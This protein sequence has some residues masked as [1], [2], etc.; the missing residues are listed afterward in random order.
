MSFLSSLITADFCSQVDARP[1]TFSYGL[2][3]GVGVNS[4]NQSLWPSVIFNETRIASNDFCASVTPPAHCGDPR[5]THG[6][7]GADVSSSWQPLPQY[8]ALDTL[9]SDVNYNI[10]YGQDRLNLFTHYF[11]PSPASNHPLPNHPITVLSDA[12]AVDDVFFDSGALGLGSSSTAIKQLIDQGRIN[13]NVVGMYL[14]TAY[15]RAGGTQNGSI[16]IG[17]YDSGRF[18]GEPH[19]YP[20]GQTSSPAVSPLKIH[21]KQLSLVTEDG[22]TIPFVTDDGFDGHIST[23]QYPMELPHDTISAL[24]TAINASPSNNDEGSLKTSQ[25]FK[26]NLTITLDDGYEITFPPEWISNASNLTPF[27]AIT[28]DTDNK[29]IGVSRPLIFGAAFLHHLYMT[30]D[31][32]ESSFYLADAKV[33]DNYV[34]PQS[35]CA[36]Q[37]PVAM[38]QP[39]IAKFV[40]MGLIGAIL[41]GLI[42]GTAII[43]VIYFYFRRRAQ[44]KQS[45]SAIS[46]MEGGGATG[47]RH[48]S[49]MR[50]RSILRLDRKTG[51]KRGSKDVTFGDVKRV[52]ISDSEPDAFAGKDMT[53]IIVSTLR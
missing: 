24:S 53:K 10:T 51:S 3:I 15:P 47:S 42:G 12:T 18:L 25:P 36:G 9:S 6:H 2:F 44:Y 31:Y 13:R 40:Q 48:K 34:Q 37:A 14:G 52:S 28:L 21:V 4:Q 30:I 7:Y 45:K 29:T 19:K 50:K 27:S 16:V 11:D 41:G 39:H 32:D 1:E 5:Y 43:S 38:A 46:K 26:G 17:G 35:L 49:S 20:I 22:T 8:S 33:F 23:H